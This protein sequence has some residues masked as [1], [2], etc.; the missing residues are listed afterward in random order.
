MHFALVLV[1]VNYFWLFNISKN[2]T[3]NALND[4]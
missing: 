4:A 2:E 1:L 3:T